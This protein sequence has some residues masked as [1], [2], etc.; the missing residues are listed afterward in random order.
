M[1]DRLVRLKATGWTR[2]PYAVFGLGVALAVLLVAAA[3]MFG[4]VGDPETMNVLEKY[5][6]PSWQ[7]P[8]GTDNFGRDV[9]SRVLAGTRNTVA[10]SIGTIL[11]GGG[12]GLLLGTVSGY[13]GGWLD[14]V[15]MRVS[16]TVFAFPGVLLA[17]V[18]VSI[19]GPGA[20]NVVLALG[21]VF[22]PSFARV[23]RGGMLQQKSEKYVELARVYGAS[24]FR[25]MLVHILPNLAPTLLS[26][27][28]VGFANAI[29]AEAGMS[30]LGLGVQP[31]AASWGKM[32]ADG[33]SDLFRAPWMVIF[34]GLAIVLAVM[35]FHAL[36][37]AIRRKSGREAR[38]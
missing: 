16:D 20:R 27:F 24:P 35:G 4:L 33:N 3:G 14:A 26:A 38:P 13:A 10:I 1:K 9:L 36:G 29:L 8:F 28:T 22:T 23:V 12:A 31:P 17:L 19:Y 11:L 37:E 6:A 25:I 2:D 18:F 5:L 7:H 15:I 34:P 30:Y 32:L 21:I